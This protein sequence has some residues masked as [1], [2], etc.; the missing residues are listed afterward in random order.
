MSLRQ[1]AKAVTDF[2]LEFQRFVDGLV[3]TLLSHRVAIALA[4]P[5]VGMPLR[6]AAINIAKD[7]KEPSL[8]I[9]NPIVESCT[10]KKDKKVECCMSLPGYGGEVERREKV[11][12]S[13]QTRSGDHAILEAKGFL[14]RVIA[15][16]VDH[17]NGILYIDRMTEPSSLRE[18]DLFDRD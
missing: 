2:G 18:V 10:G 7:K 15:H 13:Y 11:R 8:V 12:L 3:E 4:A 5:Q 14:A 1:P 17:L 6:V 9:C 16:E